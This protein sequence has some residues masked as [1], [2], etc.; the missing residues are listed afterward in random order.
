VTER[1]ADAPLNKSQA[2]S[3]S[4]PFQPVKHSLLQ[5]LLIDFLCF[6]LPSYSLSF[7]SIYLFCKALSIFPASVTLSINSSM[8]SL[9]T[10]AHK[11][12]IKN[13]KGTHAIG[14]NSMSRRSK[15]DWL[16]KPA[17]ESCTLFFWFSEDIGRWY[18]AA[19]D[20]YTKTTRLAT[21]QACGGLAREQKGTR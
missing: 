21:D 17:P 3:V 20:L 11:N 19:K 6:I 14:T 4:Q 15:H 9:G 2:Y 16:T 13:Y 1:G 5:F 8:G 12:I 18:G 7:R 10:R